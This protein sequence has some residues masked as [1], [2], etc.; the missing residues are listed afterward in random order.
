MQIGDE[1]GG[2]S[3]E[4]AV[5]VKAVLSPARVEHR[6]VQV[7]LLLREQK[8]GRTSVGIEFLLTVGF[9]HFIISIIIMHS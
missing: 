2:V 5:G 4:T 7:T 9:L 3:H 8:L 1:P 6:V